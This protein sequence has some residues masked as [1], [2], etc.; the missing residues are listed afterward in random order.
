[1]SVESYFVQ[2]DDVG[3]SQDLQNADLSGYSLHICLVDDALLLQD[4]HCDLL[5]CSYVYA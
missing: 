5:F 3:M 1:M 2:L 4:L